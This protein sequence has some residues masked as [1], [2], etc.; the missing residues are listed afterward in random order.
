MP[1]VG[2]TR[3]IQHAFALREQHPDRGHPEPLPYMPPAS[4]CG[5]HLLLRCFRHLIFR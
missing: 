5:A 2:P 3:I 4:T 1:K